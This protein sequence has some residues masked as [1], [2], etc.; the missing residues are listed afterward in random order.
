MTDT[1]QKIA[2][3]REQ[4]QKRLVDLARLIAPKVPSGQRTLGYVLPQSNRIGHLATELQVLLTRY[5]DR[6]EH[7]VVVTAPLD[8]PGT[9]RWIPQAAGS[10][11]TIIECADQMLLALGVLGA[12]LIPGP[13]FDILLPHKRPF[14]TDF[15]RYLADGHAPARFSLTE[16]TEDRALKALEGSS[17]DPTRPFVVLHIRT[18]AYMKSL[19]HH[20][21]RTATAA[22]YASSIRFL[23]E[24]GLQVLRIGEANIGEIGVEDSGFI[25]VP[26]AAPHE[27][28]VDLFALARAQF[29]LGQT[30]GPI[31]AAAAFGTP[32]VRSNLILHHLDFPQNADI[33]LYKDFR[34]N[35][36]GKRLTLIEIFNRR[37]ASVDDEKQ[38]E[39]LGVTVEDSTPDDILSATEEMFRQ[40]SSASG[41]LDHDP[42]QTRF[43]QL[44]GAY[45]AELQ[46]YAEMKARGLDFFGPAFSKDRVATVFLDTRPDFLD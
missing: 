20:G 25:E 33:S 17:F 9:N 13:G 4:A 34:D 23:L 35:K 36:S 26:R 12:G 32:V 3:M 6:Y 8:L 46:S 40:I 27:N 28:A 14:L 38:Y 30:S 10:R 24:K 18:N 39:A 21:H 11:I 19:T 43:K 45:N 2:E 5:T 16:E 15:F 42:R 7:F 1:A 41:T 44:G 37:L 29:M 31:W 22:D